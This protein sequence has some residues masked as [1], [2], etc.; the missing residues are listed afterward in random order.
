MDRAESPLMA[1]RPRIFLVA[2]EPSGDR[3]G[4]DLAAALKARLPGAVF[5]GVGG[6][7]MAAHGIASPFDINE[8]SVL[9]F[10]EGMKAYRRVVARADETAALAVAAEPDIAVLIDSWGFTLRVAT[11]LRRLL[12]GLP[13]VKY[14]GPQVWASRPGR[15]RTLARAADLVLTLQPF[16]PPYFER[17]GLKA[18][19]VGHPT[20]DREVR[21]DAQ[22]F[23]R[24]HNV[25]DSA[26]VALVL[27]GSRAGEVAR[28]APVFAEAM[29]I[30]RARYGDSVR[31][32]APL[33]SS[34]AAQAREEA[35][36]DPRLG[37]ALFVDETERNDAFAAGDVALA[38]S[39]TVVTELAM[40]GVPAVV[41]YKLGPLSHAL[42]KVVF[43]APHVSL[44]NMVLGERLLPELIQ[45]EATGEAVAAAAAH[46]LDD[47]QYTAETRRKLAVAVARMRGE[48]GGSASGRAADAVIELLEEGR[49]GQRPDLRQDR[50]DSAVAD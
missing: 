23:R 47:A 31:F 17:A 18:K 15:A 49:V 37:M 32:V 27:L 8:L 28:M 50:G 46:F 3:L 1:R 6:P 26:R 24:R 33:A 42:V 41:A 44:V 25:A 9:G 7:A 16:E 2:A 36:A 14:V 29:A 19:F 21:G 40:A 5:S 43:V 38:C 48:G 13:I 22:Q 30:I 20:L 35:A 34:V 12:P 11:R 10:I 39:G 45:S 4:G